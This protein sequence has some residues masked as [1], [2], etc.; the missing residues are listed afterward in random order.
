MLPDF[1]LILFIVILIPAYVLVR[2]FKG[3][4]EPMVLVGM[5]FFSILCWFFIAIVLYLL[6]IDL[7][8]T[9]LLVNLL[10]LLPIILSALILLA[11]V[12]LFIRKKYINKNEL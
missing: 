9:A 2:H 11:K 3:R 8:E 4:R 1:S 5:S 10:I 12:F 6:D 7:Q